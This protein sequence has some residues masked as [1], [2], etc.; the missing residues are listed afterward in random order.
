MLIARVEPN[1][2]SFP[3]LRLH[4]LC[5]V[6]VG[7]NRSS[8]NLAK[9]GLSPKHWT[10]AM[11]S[12]SAIINDIA[13]SDMSRDALNKWEKFKLPRAN[14]RIESLLDELRGVTDAEERKNGCGNSEG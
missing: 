7:T 10:H 8:A 4:S 11:S 9:S 1:D 6:E 14:D 2:V 12:L 3:Q 5:S 13:R